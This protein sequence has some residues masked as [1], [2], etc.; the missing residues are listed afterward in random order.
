MEPEEPYSGLCSFSDLKVQP[1]YILIVPLFVAFFCMT[2]SNKKDFSLRKKW[3]D[4][5]VIVQKKYIKI[6][7]QQLGRSEFLSHEIQWEN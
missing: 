5:V 1:T 3:R 7:C 6:I 2:I 4:T